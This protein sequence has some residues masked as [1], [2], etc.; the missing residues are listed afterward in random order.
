MPDTT[1]A[2]DPLSVS[3][4]AGAYNEVLYVG[5]AYPN[6][7]PDR[8]AT[9]AIL[10]GIDCAPIQSCRVLEIGCGDGANI[11][12]MA[13]A[14]PSAHFVGID[15]A[16]RPVER[17]QRMVTD[18]DLRNVR[19]AELDL[20]EFPSDAGLFDFIIAHGLYSWIPP[21]VRIQLMP[22]IARHLAPNGIA[23]VSYNLFPGC[24]VRQIVWD[25]LKFH[26]RE[27]P[28]PP[29]K[30]AAAR[31]LIALMAN[32][33]APSNSS[34][35]ALRA[36]FRKLAAVPDFG[37]LH[38]DLNDNNH[39]VHF[40]EF[41]GDAEGSGLA[42]L[43]E[44]DLSGG[45]AGDFAPSVRKML[46]RMDRL[47][48]EQYID[49]LHLRS[50]RGSLLCHAAAFPGFGLRPDRV[51][52]M[53]ASPALALRRARAT[54]QT[55]SYGSDDTRRVV[56][57]L[58]ARWP[59]NVPTG[60]VVAM[61]GEGK[62]RA[63]GERAKPSDSHTLLAELWKAGVIDLRPRAVSPASGSASDPPPMRPR[64]GWCAI[65]TLSRTSITRASNWPT[66][67][68]GGS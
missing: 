6:T 33:E 19:I 59:G 30:L 32:S 44:S 40:R 14:L 60:E 51:A 66:R 47:A 25:M 15:Y 58:T 7:H 22:M 65:R 63:G 29:S 18:L 50:F 20:R 2:A 46:E 67:W 54:G 4:D 11:V 24:R 38:D 37:L 52:S 43:V 10:H 41:V 5:Q 1:S 16:A 42:F 49:F 26:T 64:A 8:L 12:P 61:L 9:L 31:S 21:D 39:P 55:I 36:E 68:R 56:E 48:A 17:A 27:C 35:E 13:A 23:Y 53:H 45:A 62:P 28:N 3:P 57:L 34:E